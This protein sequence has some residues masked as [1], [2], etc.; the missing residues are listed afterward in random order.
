MHAHTFIQTIIVENIR[1]HCKTILSHLLLV[2]YLVFLIF[3]I[4]F[5]ESGMTERLERSGGS[6]QQGLFEVDT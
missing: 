6:F 1:L 5:I 4:V 3:C 2:H